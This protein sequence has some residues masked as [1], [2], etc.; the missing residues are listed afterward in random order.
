M[1][2]LLFVIFHQE[3]TLPRLHLVSV[4]DL[5]GHILELC[6][7]QNSLTL[8]KITVSSNIQGKHDN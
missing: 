1:A 5:F 3:R 4:G 8:Q 7:F 6:K 2:M